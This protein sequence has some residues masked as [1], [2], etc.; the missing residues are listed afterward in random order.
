M[1]RDVQN[2]QKDRMRN[3]H[4]HQPNRKINSSF[5]SIKV[6]N[7]APFSFCYCVSELWKRIY[8]KT[9]RWTLWSVG[10][11][12]SSSNNKRINEINFTKYNLITIA[13]L[14]M[15]SEHVRI[16]FC[17]RLR[18]LNVVVVVL[19]RNKRPVFVF[20]YTRIFQSVFYF[21]SSAVLSILYP[22]F[23]SRATTSTERPEFK[24][25]L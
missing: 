23:Y 1:L 24:I 14:F 10:N 22:T 3:R 21:D 2:E 6:V 19:L 8:T 7:V 17:F 9:P 25:W 12:S 16:I 5:S 11:D 20:E 4:L 13:F 15:E 18:S